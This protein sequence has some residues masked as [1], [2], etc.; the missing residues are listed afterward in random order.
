MMQKIAVIIPVLN[1]A[2]SIGGAIDRVRLA[3]VHCVVVDGGSDDDTA[4]V[5]A[6]HGARVISSRRGRAAQMNAGALAAGDFEVLVFLHADVVLPD[7]WAEAVGG[8]ID[9][10]AAW[11][12]FDVVL[13]SPVRLLTVVGAMMNL[14]SRFT[15]IATGDQAIFI[16]R[17]AFDALGGYAELP[18]MEDVEF[19]TR[20][21]RARLPAA[22]LRDRVSVSAR[23]WE[24]KGPLRTIVLMWVVRAL[25]WLGIPARHLHRIYYG[26]R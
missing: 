3:G 20:L 21:R 6:S 19:C 18:L 26:R 11:G 15:G 16:R 9:A 5:A 1:E 12:R 8:A 24:T 10:G 14:R 2:A 7:N 22:P 25:F 23:R 4:A 13:D 17:A